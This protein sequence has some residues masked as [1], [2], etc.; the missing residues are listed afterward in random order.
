[1]RNAWN[2]ANVLEFSADQRERLPELAERTGVSR[3]IEEME[4]AYR[5]YGLPTTKAEVDKLTQDDLKRLQ[6]NQIAM[7]R[8]LMPSR[9]RCDLSELSLSEQVLD[10]ATP[11]Q[12]LEYAFQIKAFRD[13]LAVKRTTILAI[14]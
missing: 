10:L 7:A 1:M 2:F 3:C 8:E 4:T 14:R 12:R 9:R 13:V 6:P 5:R 11:E